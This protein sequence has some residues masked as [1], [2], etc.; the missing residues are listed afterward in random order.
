MSQKRG[1]AVFFGCVIAI[2]VSYVATYSRFNP[3]P[4]TSS[5]AASSAPAPTS[6][7]A[8]QTTELV[9]L[10][11][12]LP[13]ANGPLSWARL[14]PAQRAA[15]APFAD[16]WDGFSDARK[17][18]WLKIASRFAKLTPDEQKHLQDRM[19]EWAR[20]TPEQRRVARENYQSAKE[21]S[22]QARERAWKA[23]QQL[24]EEQKQR[25]AA[26][27]RR[28]RP[29]VVSAPPAV[30]DRDVRRLVNSH[31]HPASSAAPA[32]APASPGAGAPPVTASSTS[33]TAPAPATVTPVSPADAPSMFKGS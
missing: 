5:V 12:P 2:A 19:S 13:A 6:A 17:R 16:Q 15:L 7:A 27:E 1:L 22:A 8:G 18:K 23:Y 31:E 3:P 20:M 14:T 21:L 26:T 28:R 4:A 11:L 29:S 25:L 33:G 24:P 9:P 30:A 10:P 32:S